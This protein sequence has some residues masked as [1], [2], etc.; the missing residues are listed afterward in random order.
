[1][2]GGKVDSRGSLVVVVGEVVLFFFTTG[3]WTRNRVTRRGEGLVKRIQAKARS[4]CG[5]VFS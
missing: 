2:D 4:G 1:M 5:L 3:V